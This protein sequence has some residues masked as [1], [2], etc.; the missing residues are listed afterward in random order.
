MKSN[1]RST[2]SYYRTLYSKYG[3]DDAF[4]QNRAQRRATG[5]F[6]ERVDIAQSAHRQIIDPR[7]HRQ[8]KRAFRD[9][10]LFNAVSTAATV[11]AM[12]LLLRIT[13]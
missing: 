5:A 6:L 11:S 2:T 9:T 13:V 10:S 7:R 8:L 3:V 12:V 1:N 4:L